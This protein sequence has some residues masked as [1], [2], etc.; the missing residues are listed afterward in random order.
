VPPSPAGEPPPV[1]ESESPAITVVPADPF[2]PPAEPSA[3]DTIRKRA[4]A[5][6]AKIDKDLRKQSLNKFSAPDDSPQKRLI[7]GIESARRNPTLFE[8]AEIEEITKGNTD[9][10]SRKYRIK[11]GLGTY[12]VTYPSAND[13]M[14]KKTYSLCPK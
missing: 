13:P 1:P 7:A 8:K 11:T 2:A 6:L 10:G 4:F 5:D 14:G 12:C 9:G 3:A